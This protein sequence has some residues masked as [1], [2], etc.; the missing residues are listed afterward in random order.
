L[1]APDTSRALAAHVAP[2]GQLVIVA[3]ASAAADGLDPLARTQLLGAM[4]RGV[5]HAVLYLG[6]SHV[7]S[8]L[9]PSLALVRD[10]GTRFA[11]RLCAQPDLEDQR[12]RAAPVI[13]DDDLADPLRAVP[14]M[15]GAEYVSSDVLR[16]WWNAAAA[17]FAAELAAA[18]GTVQEWLRAFGSAW[19]VVGK[20]CFH[21]AEN[22]ADPEHP[23]A[24]LAT[25]VTRA[26]TKGKVAHAPLS[27]ALAES[28]ARGDNAALL[29]LLV[30]VQRAAEH[31]AFVRALLEQGD[32]YHPLAWSPREAHH[33]LQE[34]PALEAAGVTVRVPDWWRARRPL[35]P[36]VRVTVGGKAPGAG[37]L[38]AATMLDFSVDVTLD[39]EPLSAGELRDLL[40]RREGLALVRG[41]WVELD[42]DKL[43]DVLSHWQDVQRDAGKDGLSFLAG[44]RLLAG[45]PI[46]ERDAVDDGVAAWTRVEAGTWLG[47]TLAGLR[48]PDALVASDLGDALH[49]ELRPYQQ[50]GVNWL[51]FAARLRLGVCL[52]D[53]MGLG[54]T[55]QVLALMLLA[56]REARRGADNPPH[57]LIVPASLLGNWQAEA[58]RFA[59]S[60]R[61][62]VAHASV[63]PSKELAALP[64]KRLADVDVVLTT[65][66]AAARVPWVAERDW[67]L[68]V[69]DEAQAI[70]NPGTR[71]ARAVK[72]LRARSR[73]ALTG[74]PVENRLADLWSLFDFL[75]PGLLGTPKQFS[76]FTKKLAA[77]P[78][79]PYAPL[80]RLVQPYLLRRLKTDKQV[81]ADLPDKTELKTFCGL[82]RP[83][84]ALYQQTVEDLASELRAAREG[85]KRR[86]V[87]L[88]YLMRF[89]QICN[90]PAHWLR[91]GVWA[92]ADSGKLQRLRELGEEIVSRQEKMLVFTQFREASEPLAAF[93]A[94]V[95]GRPGLVLHGDTPIK[96]RAELVA[97]FQSDE[98][99]PF[100]VLSLKAGGTG[101]N[102]TAASHVVHFDRWWNPAVENQATDR[103]FRIGQR[104]NVLV[105]KLICR[106]TVEERID[107][108]IDGKKDMA[109]S[110]M[111]STGG[112]ETLL[113]ELK[114]EQLLEL[115]A[116]DLTRAATE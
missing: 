39:G 101:L 61:L 77:R 44:M 115:V 36:E 50:T 56:Q 4:A 9:A 16:M 54:K 108:M 38:S 53:D 40:A 1:D 48:G 8:A 111:G 63:L 87:V 98:R 95:C 107:A 18:G 60:L 51:W 5:G 13:G 81:I 65:Y 76:A 31:S 110:L 29:S 73:I 33:F 35:R 91:D 21:L 72:A 83:Q 14:P 112:A 24:F 19:N 68:L 11:T 75:E 62:L 84:A 104:R 79:E 42:R 28:S 82:A 43:R 46:A 7:D 34:I 55:I 70:K 92:E 49:A 105:H 74:T 86:G 85:I 102:L 78:S 114:D 58:A 15:L 69:L 30:P 57:L 41:K 96:K 27:R 10:L 100:F 90:H 67:S 3:D 88:A 89:K 116:L 17:A 32:L 80:R 37:A 71:Q 97:R 23:F 22:P 66:G 25:Y 93:L 64:A 26:T 106:G 47:K 94:E 113:T 109:E 20:V 12:E 103:A 45:A 6:L 99:V 52:A 2:A 59:P